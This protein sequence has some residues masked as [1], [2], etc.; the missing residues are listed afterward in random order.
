MDQHVTL[1][2][3]EFLVPPLSAR[4]IIAY[5]KFASALANMNPKAVA[6]T[7]LQNIYQALLIGLQQGLPN[8]S[9]D[10]LL[11]MPIPISEAMSALVVVSRQAG[12]ADPENPP[13]QAVGQA[14]I[15]PPTKSN[16]TSGSPT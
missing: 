3:R 7:D 12:I 11:D 2:G 9:L 5:T 10:E 8:L 13:D 4:R 16:G 14:P 15:S 1:A 6:E